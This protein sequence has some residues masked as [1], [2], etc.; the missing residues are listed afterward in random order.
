MNSMLNNIMVGV[1]LAL[2]GL[3]ACGCRSIGTPAEISQKEI[4]QRDQ[5]SSRVAVL[6]KQLDRYEVAYADAATNNE[7]L[8]VLQKVALI[9][10]KYRTDVFPC[11]EN[12]KELIDRTQKAVDKR[13]A[14][15]ELKLQIATLEQQ[16][17]SQEGS[18]E[19]ADICEKVLWL[20][21]DA[22][23][24]ILSPT[25]RSQLKST[26]RYYNRLKVG[27]LCSHYHQLALEAY[28]T[29][30]SFDDFCSVTQECLDVF[31][32]ELRSGVLTDKERTYL[33]ERLA[34][35]ISLR[36]QAISEYEYI[37]STMRQDI[38][39]L[40]VDYINDSA[41]KDYQHARN[42]YLAEKEKYFNFFCWRDN[43]RS[44]TTAVHC[45][46]RIGSDNRVD[47]ILR[48]E[49]ASMRHDI[50]SNRFDRGDRK[51][52]DNQPALPTYTALDNYPR[53]DDDVLANLASERWKEINNSEL[54][55]ERGELGNGSAQKMAKNQ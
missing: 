53:L 54:E 31:T 51:C 2:S 7:R 32:R 44:L 46:D 21:K 5:E 47:Y 22:P 6:R 43:V 41:K 3:S 35:I 50:Y 34:E 29:A 48:R 19:K 49:A 40:Q 16:L 36:S 4:M 27:Y 25:E 45:L 52:F 12:T 30:Q 15:L 13:I 24:N 20:I 17:D 33:K 10:G 1:L 37:L 18:L 26:S 11:E 14:G 23:E 9:L 8:E 28:N 39:S 42:L 38:D 55:P